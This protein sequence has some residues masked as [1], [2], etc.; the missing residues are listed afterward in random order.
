MQYFFP[1]LQ[2]KTNL[3]LFIIWTEHLY[4]NFQESTCTKNTSVN[5]SMNEKVL[6]MKNVD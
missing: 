5:T 4:S 3:A 6:S 2:N 1:S